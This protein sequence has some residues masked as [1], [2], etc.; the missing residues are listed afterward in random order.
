MFC[1]ENCCHFI[2]SRHFSSNDKIRLQVSVKKKRKKKHY[3]SATPHDFSL[4]ERFEQATNPEV[5]GLA[6]PVDELLERD[7]AIGNKVIR[8]QCRV[9]EDGDTQH[10]RVLHL[11][12]EALVPH[13]VE[14]LRLGGRAVQVVLV[15]VQLHVRIEHRLVLP[16]LPL[17]VGR[18]E[19][20]R[21]ANLDLHRACEHRYFAMIS[22]TDR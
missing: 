19:P 16:E 21:L 22:A 12:D 20:H 1:I 3:N 5:G 15:D 2:N 9:V 4:T 18:A 11:D 10:G 6:V 14:G 13:R 7:G 8:R 17:L